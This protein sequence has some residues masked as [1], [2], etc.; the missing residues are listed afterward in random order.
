MIAVTKKDNLEAIKIK[1][2]VMS[3]KKIYVNAIIDI[4]F[5]TSS[6]FLFDDFEITQSSEWL[7]EQQPVINV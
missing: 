3:E 6:I 7:I 4:S 5:I 2:D 1:T